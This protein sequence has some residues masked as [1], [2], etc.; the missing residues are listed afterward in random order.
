[1]LPLFKTAIYV[2]ASSDR[3]RDA[4]R[5]SDPSL[6]ITEKKRWATGQKLLA[7]ARGRGEELPLIF[8]QYAPLT[9]WAVAREITLH[10]LTTEYQFTELRPLRDHR[11]SDLV[12]ESTG[13]PL[14]DEFIRS[15]ALVRT[16]EFL[17]AEHSA[18][19]AAPSL[20]PLVEG[21]ASSVIV[22]AYERNPLAREKC[23]QHYGTSCFACGFSFRET[24]GERITGCIH[25]HHLESVAA[26]GGEYV[27]DPVKDLRP[28]CPNC[29]AVLHLRKPP[30]S[31]QE[32][33][34]MLGND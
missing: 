5:G 15:Y 2:N 1:M 9:F 34:T 16:P 32:L 18:E 20:A 11:R 33:K 14:P 7:E 31:I 19:L 17:V 6:P 10:A 28:V 3:L 13:A 4:S 27:V 22:T 26:R 25:V 23:L 29:H 8:A 24:Y 30:L 12:V 21:A